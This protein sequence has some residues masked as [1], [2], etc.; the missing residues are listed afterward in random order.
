MCKLNY[1]N[2]KEVILGLK[3]YLTVNGKLPLAGCEKFDGGEGSEFIRSF[4]AN[5]FTLGYPQSIHDMELSLTTEIKKDDADLCG[6]CVEVCLYLTY[7]EETV[8]ASTSKEKLCAIILSSDCS[9]EAYKAVTNY[10]VTLVCGFREYVG[11]LAKKVVKTSGIMDIRLWRLP[12]DSPVM[13]FSTKQ[14]EKM[15]GLSVDKSDYYMALEFT[16][17][18]VMHDFSDD[19]LY[20]LCKMATDRYE[21]DRG[22]GTSDVFEVRLPDGKWRVLYV[23]ENGAVTCSEKKWKW[24]V[25]DRR[26]YV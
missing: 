1:Y 14:L 15:T 24:N 19:E 11:L 5:D 9:E 25:L 4:E 17:E 26:G 6:Q 3:S 22:I 13:Y 10:G 7:V 23:E 18:Y 2:N 8:D 20:C 21:L 16:I 12:D